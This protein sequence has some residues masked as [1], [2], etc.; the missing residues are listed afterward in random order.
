MLKRVGALAR[1]KIEEMVGDEV[2]LELWVKV[3]EKWSKNDTFLNM[4]G[5][6]RDS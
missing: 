6:T 5:Y 1:K 3:K 2:Y 4:V